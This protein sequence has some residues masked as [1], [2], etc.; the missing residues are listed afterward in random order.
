MALS[1]LQLP[2]KDNPN[3]PL[4]KYMVREIVDA[5]VQG[6][7]RV[8]STTITVEDDV[9]PFHAIRV[10]EIDGAVVIVDGYHR[11]SAMQAYATKK[12]F[13]CSKIQMPVNTHD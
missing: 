10:C 1:R 6:L 9:S 13:D 3:D 2:D 12:G 5:N 8:L 11:T 7:L 4:H